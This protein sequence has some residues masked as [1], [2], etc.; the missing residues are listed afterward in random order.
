MKQLGTDISIRPFSDASR[1]EYIQGNFD[2]WCVCYFSSNKNGT[3][4]SSYKSHTDEEMLTALQV[5]ADTSGADRVY[6]DVKQI[7][8]YVN[9]NFDE[10]IYGVID[11]ILAHYEFDSE[12]DYLYIGKLFFWFYLAMISEENKANTQLGKKIKFLAI[13]QI[14]IEG[15]TPSKA[16]NFSKGASAKMLIAKCASYGI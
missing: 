11:D 5:L 8:D 15:Y 10:S 4:Q 6:G 7:Y 9:K 13:H 12:E 2:S 16:A 14:L 3:V 1:F